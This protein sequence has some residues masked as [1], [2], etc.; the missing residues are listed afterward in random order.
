MALT[1]FAVTG[2]FL[3]VA[4]QELW[5]AQGSPVPH[6]VSGTVTF[7]PLFNVGEATKTASAVLV[8]QPVLAVIK[9]GVLSRNGAA[10]CKLVA[11]TSDLNL[12]ELFYRVTFFGL[13]AVNGEE[14]LLNAFDFLAPSAAVTVDMAVLNPVAGAPAL[15]RPSSSVTGTVVSAAVPAT[16]T[17]AGTVGQVAYNST[18][19][20][21]CTAT[22][23]WRRAALGTW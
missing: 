23:T 8:L 7:T 4:G 10:G 22:N 5:D 18:H 16:A 15:G 19:I 6:P 2:N 9:D 11:N 20:Y 14:I 13:R 17:S 3:S 12:E 1:H 21:I